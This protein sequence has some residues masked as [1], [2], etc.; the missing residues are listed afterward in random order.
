MIRRKRYP[1]ATTRISYKLDDSDWPTV[2]PHAFRIANAAVEQHAGRTHSQILHCCWNLRKF[3][4]AVGWRSGK[5]CALNCAECAHGHAK[6]SGLLA[7]AGEIHACAPQSG[8]SKIF[9]PRNVNSWTRLLSFSL[10]N[11]KLWSSHDIIIA[12]SYWLI[13][14][15]LHTIFNDAHRLS[16]H[17]ESHWVS[18]R[19]MMIICS[20]F[21]LNVRSSYLTVDFVQQKTIPQL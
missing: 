7:K 9:A 17:Y 19:C 13:S 18:S 5:L 10:D 16:I 8:D 15:I 2:K 14:Y 6:T 1:F 20:K 11:H 21:Y 4:H 3:V 12:L